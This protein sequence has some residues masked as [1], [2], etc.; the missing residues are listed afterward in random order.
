MI[1]FRMNVK[2]I[3]LSNDDGNNSIGS[4]VLIS[5]LKNKYELVVAGPKG[6]QSSVG[7]S[8]TS[9]GFK[10]GIEEILGV[11]SYWVDGTPSDAI[12]LIYSQ[13]KDFDIIISGINWGPNISSYLYRSG[14]YQ[15]VTCA[16]GF[17]LV[18]VGISLSW[19]VPPENWYKDTKGT[20]DI[21]KYLEVPGKMAER[22]INETIENDLWGAEILNINFP[23]VHTKEYRFTRLTKFHQDAFDRSWK[24]KDNMYYYKGGKSNDHKDQHSDTNAITEGVVSITPCRFDL[25]DAALFDSLN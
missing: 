14:T 1:K 16:I 8:V 10:W 17:N 15:A 2:R 24:P 23:S 3:L 4:R 9:K 19:D 7:A 20:P 5:L 13:E 18:P 6:Q 22:M 21:N 12:E 25:T 11:K